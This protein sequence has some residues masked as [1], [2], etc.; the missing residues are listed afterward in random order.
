MSDII[1]SY[2]SKS[3]I[4]RRKINEAMENFYKDK[5]QKAQENIQSLNESVSIDTENKAIALR[6]T[7]NRIKNRK[8]YLKESVETINGI[9][10]NLIKECF[11]YIVYSALPL[12][13]DFKKHEP[14][15]RYIIEQASNLFETLS[16]EN[17]I[18]IL[19]NSI[20]GGI[21]SNINAEVD[22]ASGIEVKEMAKNIKEHCKFE[23]ETCINVLK[24]KLIDVIKVERKMTENK[25]LIESQG[26]IIRE[27]E[28]TKTL[29]KRLFEKN[30]S[31]VVESKKEDLDK[32]DIMSLAFSESILDYALLEGLYTLKCIDIDANRL[33]TVI[34]FI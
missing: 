34:K 10:E 25:E 19:E 17:L 15:Q 23:F 18:K 4:R 24:E 20:F 26:R 29:F 32:K 27:N 33:N 3:S 16:N 31:A 5:E 13:E 28:A 6:D 21:C 7:S 9:K 12:D 14:N 30:I 2:G 8:T 22:N 11:G 1:S